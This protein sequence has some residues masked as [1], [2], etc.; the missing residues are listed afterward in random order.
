M[1]LLEKTVAMPRFD[2]LK[3]LTRGVH[4]LVFNTDDMKK[5]IDFYCDVL[6]MHLVHALKT[7]PGITSA[8]KERGN[9]PY[10]NIRHYFF[11]MGNDS[12]LAFFEMPKNSNPKADRDAVGGMQ[13]TSFVVS[14]DSEYQELMRRLRANGVDFYGPIPMGSGPGFSI[15]FFDPN[16]I[17]LEVSCIEVGTPSVIDNVTQTKRQ[18]LDELKT[19]HDDPNWL[20]KVTVGLPD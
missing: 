3:P 13:H 2:K 19:L 4:H 9:P 5:T 11:D 18:I 14:K 7:E 16:G 12:V 10:E 17:R 15:Y 1:T 6:G 8:S 20:A